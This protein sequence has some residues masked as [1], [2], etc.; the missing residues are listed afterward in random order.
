MAPAIFSHGGR[1]RRDDHEIQA[2]DD[3]DVLAAEAPREVRAMAAQLAH[4]PPVAV[5][6]TAP[7]GA[8]PG[9]ERAIDPRL[10]HHLASLDP[11]A[12]EIELPERQHLP[13]CQQHVVAAE[14]DALR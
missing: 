2:G 1:G 12:I 3:E 4:P 5:F 8:G 6:L 11:A 10:R 13:W 9:D 14:V 7:E